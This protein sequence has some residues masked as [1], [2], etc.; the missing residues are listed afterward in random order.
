MESRIVENLYAAF[1]DVRK[2]SSFPACPCCMTEAEV[3]NVLTKPLRELSSKELSSYASSALLTVGDV[4]D[5]LYYLP[6]IL[7]ISATEAWW[8]DIEVTAKAIFKTDPSSWPPS[9]REPTEEFFRA[10]IDSIVSE[11]HDAWKLDEWI[12]AIGR[13]GFDVLPALRQIENSVDLLVAYY[14]M[15]EEAL[16]S[17]HLRNAFWKPDD[18][19]YERVI[20]W[21]GSERIGDLIVSKKGVAAAASLYFSPDPE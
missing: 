15:N 14:E 19:G 13:S 11:S 16:T 1:G 6:R 18:P 3:Q 5:Y 8:P 17:R 10:V 2:P 9:R 20:A 12:C 21:F 7:E 4:A